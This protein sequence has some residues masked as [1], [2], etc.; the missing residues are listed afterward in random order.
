MLLQAVIRRFSCRGL[1]YLCADGTGTAFIKLA[2]E[3]HSRGDALTGGEELLES[4]LGDHQNIVHK[5]FTK[6]SA[7]QWALYL[8]TLLWECLQYVVD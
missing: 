4:A 8:H 6:L 5:V 1:G 3:L 2:C 7:S